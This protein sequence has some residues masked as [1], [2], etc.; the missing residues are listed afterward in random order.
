MAVWKE[1]GVEKGLIASL[2]DVSIGA[3]WS[4]VMEAPVGVGSPTAGQINTTAIISQVSHS[5]SAAMRC[6]N[7]SNPETG[8]GVYTDWYL[9]AIWEM[10]QLYNAAFVVNTVLGA[11]DGFQQTRYWSSTEFDAS[12][13]WLKNFNSANA[14]TDGTLLKSVSARV[15]CVRRF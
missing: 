8:T 9:P 11:T 1:A 6:D 12:S 15:R 5:D 3:P 10:T 13:A 14:A 2:I 4:Y 7:F